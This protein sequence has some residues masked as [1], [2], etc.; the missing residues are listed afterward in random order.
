[1]SGSG[2]V[3]AY[4]HDERVSHCF[5]D[6]LMNAGATGVITGR[7]PVRVTSGDVGGSRDRAVTAFL[8]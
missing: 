4:L 6:A 1:M 2:L 8:Q 3:V 7:L 5:M